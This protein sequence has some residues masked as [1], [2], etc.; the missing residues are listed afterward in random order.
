MTQFNRRIIIQQ[1]NGYVQRGKAQ[2]SNNIIL[3]YSIIARILRDSIS[4]WKNHNIVKI[5]FY[6]TLEMIGIS[7]LAVLGGHLR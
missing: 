2:L 7:L 6:K 4:S 3:L 5:D 1:S